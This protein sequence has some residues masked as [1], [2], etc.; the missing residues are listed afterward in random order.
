MK[1]NVIVVGTIKK[2]FF[3]EFSFLDLNPT[4][5]LLLNVSVVVLFSWCCSCT[6]ALSC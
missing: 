5:I 6:P 4:L 2:M 3:N 1:E